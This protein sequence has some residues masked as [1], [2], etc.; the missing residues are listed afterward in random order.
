MYYVVDTRAG[1]RLAREQR[2]VPEDEAVVG[3]VEAMIAGPVDPD[4]STTW[5]P[6]TEVLDIER[7]AGDVTVDLSDDARTA[8]VGSAGAALM[9]QQLVYTV[10]EV[11]GEDLQVSLLIEGEPA[12][13]LWGA[14]SWT[15]PVLRADPLDVRQLVQIDSP[16]DGAEVTSPVRITGDAAVFEATLLWR[17]LDEAGVEVN[18]GAT[19]TAE[20]Q[21]FAQY[22]FPLT[23]EPGVYTIEVSEDDPSGEGAGGPP[24]TDTKTITVR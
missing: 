20:G 6:D 5:N 9:I 17:V 2:D 7:D 23:L 16:R 22:A 15:D 14:V 3:A 18:G 21:T 11:L 10:T 24:M 19:L 1:V 4:Y 12:G 13:E 8:N